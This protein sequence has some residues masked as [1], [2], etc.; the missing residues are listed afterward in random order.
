MDVNPVTQSILNIYDIEFCYGSLQQKRFI[1]F[2]TNR[3]VYTALYV[4]TYDK[5]F[6]KLSPVYVFMTKKIIFI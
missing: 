6:S 1:V 5:A 3:P 4:K 2:N